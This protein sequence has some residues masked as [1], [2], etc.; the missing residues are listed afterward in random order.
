MKKLQTQS[1]TVELLKTASSMGD[2]KERLKMQP[3]QASER[4]D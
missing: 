2:V 1:L 4:S 3:K